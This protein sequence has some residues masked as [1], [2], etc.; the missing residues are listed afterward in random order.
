[1]LKII[2]TKT[3]PMST[4]YIL[5]EEKDHSL[6]MKTIRNLQKRILN[7]K[8]MILDILNCTLKSRNHYSLF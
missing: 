3:I 2:F 6:T 7:M 8:A 5:S 4:Y 1:M